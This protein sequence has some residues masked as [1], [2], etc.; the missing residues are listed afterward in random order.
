M[1]HYNGIRGFNLFVCW[2]HIYFIKYFRAS[3]PLKNIIFLLGGHIVLVSLVVWD[4]QYRIFILQ[5]NLKE[6]KIELGLLSFRCSEE[7]LLSMWALKV[8]LFIIDIYITALLWMKISS[9]CKKDRKQCSF[10]VN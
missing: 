3:A 7:Q 8:F 6:V 10:T 4:R 9:K 1:Y 5:F 2:N